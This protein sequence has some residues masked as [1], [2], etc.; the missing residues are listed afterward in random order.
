MP[1]IPRRGRPWGARRL[2][3][4]L[5]I[6]LALVA[7]FS[8]GA[9]AW[10]PQGHYTVGVIAAEHLAGTRAEQEV[11]RILSGESLA[12]AALWADCVKG[13]TERPPMRYVENPRYVDCLPFQVA[14]GEHEMVD[15]VARNVSTCMPRAGEDACHRQYH[16][17]D[18]AIQ[19][20]R[21]EPTE[22]G[23]SDHDVV[24]AIRACIAVLKGRQ[25]PAP[26]SIHSPQEALR[27][28][29]HFVGDI[30][31]PLHVGAVYLDEGGR[32][33]DPDR[34]GFEPDAVTRG[35]NH[36]LHGKKSLHAEWDAVPRTLQANL[37]AERGAQMARAV[38]VTPGPVEDWPAAWATETLK[39]SGEAYAPL[40]FGAGSARGGWPVDEPAGYGVRRT[41]L[42]Q[43]QLVRAGARLAQLLEAIWP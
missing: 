33:I 6:F 35:G 38:S 15:Y 21:Y 29:S 8:S 24:G 4:H 18:I 30:H 40:R 10:G 25:S 11:R 42:Q 36:L 5:T 7:G 22:I 14:G 3:V 19:R 39:V 20:D 9:Q 1:R 32:I 2:I 16:Y 43:L 37:F 17:A 26:F 28:L 31:Q 13:V 23:A 34:R 12:T 41:A 27:L